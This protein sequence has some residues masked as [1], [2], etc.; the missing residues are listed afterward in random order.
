MMFSS[1][2]FWF[3]YFADFSIIFP[4]DAAGPINSSLQNSL[5]IQLSSFIQDQDS[6][7]EL[8]SDELESFFSFD[9]GFSLLSVSD[10]SKSADLSDFLGRLKSLEEVLHDDLVKNHGKKPLE[11][12]QN[13]TD[14]DEDRLIIVDDPPKDFVTPN[15]RVVLTRN[16]PCSETSKQLRSVVSN[17]RC[18][19][20]TLEDPRSQVAKVNMEPPT[21]RPTYQQTYLVEQLTQPL[22]RCEG[23]GKLFKKIGQHKCKGI[24]ASI[25]ASPTYPSTSHS[26]RFKCQICLRSFRSENQFQNHLASHLEVCAVTRPS[27]LSI[28]KK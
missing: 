7:P 22:T 2:E 12:S 14:E 21:R 23:C 17:R 18:S 6:L 1:F 11:P 8:D 15:Q 27:P 9:A 4:Q 5:E 24:I 10:K 19:L 20:P 26:S 25:I 3:V 13:S 28:K 16:P